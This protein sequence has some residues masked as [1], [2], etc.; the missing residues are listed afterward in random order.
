MRG[1]LRLVI[2]DVGGEGVEDVLNTVVFHGLLPVLVVVRVGPR[3][4]TDTGVCGVGFQF[5]TYFRQP[6]ATCSTPLGNPVRMVAAGLSAV[7]LV[8]GLATPRTLSTIPRRTPRVLLST[9]PR[10]ATG[11]NAR[12]APACCNVARNS[13]MNIIDEILLETKFVRGAG[14]LVE[15]PVF[16]DGGDDT[17]FDMARWEIHRSSNRCML[18]VPVELGNLDKAAPCANVTSSICFEQ[19]VVSSRAFWSAPPHDALPR[20]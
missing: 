11:A 4:F 10:Y 9:S 15:Q 17:P 8:L 12:H 14:G 20:R 1:L 19:T 2:R 13:V 6:S 7:S 3:V 5:A 18:T 16:F